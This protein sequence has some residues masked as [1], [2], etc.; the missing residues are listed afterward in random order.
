MKKIYIGCSLTH[1]PH[2]FK[3]AIE[4]LKNKLRGTYEILD[5]LGL[6]KDTPQGVYKWD[7]HCVKICDL[8]VADCTHPGIGLGYELGVALENNKPVLA[9]AHKD[10]KVTRMVLGITHPK[11]TFKRY[12]DMVEVEEFIQQK[13]KKI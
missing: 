2:E 4:D 13:I 5:F 3:L 11:Y 7:T 10:A 1:A 9:V 6:D 8:F 12:D